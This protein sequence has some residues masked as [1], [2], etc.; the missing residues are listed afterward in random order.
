MV[1]GNPVV[2]TNGMRFD[3]SSSIDVMTATLIMCIALD[4]VML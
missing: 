1:E 3:A 2:Y 4:K